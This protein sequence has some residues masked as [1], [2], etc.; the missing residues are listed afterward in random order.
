MEYPDSLITAYPV[1]GFGFGFKH[2][3]AQFDPSYD[4]MYVGVTFDMKTQGNT[5]SVDAQVAEVCS[6]TN[7]DDLADPYYSDAFPAPGCTYS[8]MTTIGED[9]TAQ[10]NDYSAQQTKI[11]ASATCIR[12]TRTCRT[13]SGRRIA[14]FGTS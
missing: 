3:N 5:V 7:G 2:D 14:F 4:G 12:C 1:A 13:T 8:K 6:G 11:L 10:G 9:L